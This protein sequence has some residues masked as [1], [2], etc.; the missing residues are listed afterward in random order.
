MS[1]FHTGYSH[2]PMPVECILTYLR[3]SLVFHKNWNRF[4]E[5]DLAQ[6]LQ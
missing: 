1:F 6:I 5:N 2:V 4:R 3:Q